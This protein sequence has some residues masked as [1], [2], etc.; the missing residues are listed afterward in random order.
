M[1]NVLPICLLLTIF[2]GHDVFPQETGFKKSSLRTG[3]GLGLAEGNREIGLGTVY[4]VGWQ[5]RLGEKGKLRLSHDL[6]LGG[7]RGVGITDIPEQFFRVSAFGT[8]LHY[9]LLTIQS[10]SL[11]VSFGGFAAY[12]R[13]LMGTGGMPEVGRTSSEYFQ[14][15][16]AGGSAS[17]GFRIDRPDSK[18]AWEIRPVSISGGY[19]NFMIGY[20]MVSAEVKFRQ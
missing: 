2:S 6:T 7:F 9:D 14:T 17:A 1:K 13:G 15:L 18:T 3:I 5:K 10:F 8:N 19:K 12:S 20:L 16:Y 4:A 11:V